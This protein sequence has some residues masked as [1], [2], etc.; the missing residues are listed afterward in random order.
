MF[1]IAIPIIPI[2]FIADNFYIDRFCS[3]RFHTDTFHTD[4]FCLCTPLHTHILAQS[5]NTMSRGGHHQ[6]SSHASLSG[7]VL[8]THISYYKV[9]ILCPEVGT[10][11]RKTGATTDV[12]GPARVLASLTVRSCPLH[13]HILV[14]SQNTM[15]RGGHQQWNYTRDQGP[16]GRRLV[17][18]GQTRWNSKFD[19]LVC[20]TE[21]MEG[22]DTRQ[23]ILG[24]DLCLC[25]SRIRDPG[26]GNPDPGC[27]SGIFFSSRILIVSILDPQQSILTFKKAKKIVS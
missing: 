5:Q 15:S 16:L 22:E 10:N 17:T 6:W 8:S 2:G 19:A 21:L 14:Q 1:N 27:G 13:T 11:N 20:L 24:N 4:M 25:L 18:P 9:K 3:D 12:Q 26:S 7:A 23:V